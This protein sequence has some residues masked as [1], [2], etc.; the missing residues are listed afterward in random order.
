MSIKI[1][2]VG[3]SH[4]HIYN[5]VHALVSAGAELV[6][7]H[8]DEP[9][10]AAEFSARYPQAK[11]VTA[12]EQILEDESIHL[13]AS[14]PIPNQRAALGVQVMGH[15]KDYSCAKPA[16]T[17]L[18][19]LAEARAVQAQTKRI[20][21][22]HFGERYD[23]AATVKA[24]ELVHSGRIG[25][26]IH[27]IGIGPHKLLGHIPRP[28]WSFDKQYFG[29]VITDLASHQVDQFLYFTGSD[30]AQ[31]TLSQVGNLNHPQ[32]SDFEDF[33]DLTIRSQNATGY[34]RVDWFTPQGLGTWGDVRLFLMGTDGYI[35]VRKIID[36]GGREGGNHLFVVDQR[37]TEHIDCSSVPLPYGAQLIDDVLNR[38]ETAMNQANCFLACELALIAQRDAVKL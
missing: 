35:E 16:F 37:G 14:A 26:V 18:D 23:N 25:R 27:M 7:F 12:V 38:T 5:Q 28:E 3:L 19:Q 32:F 31:I 2:A 34:I 17:T 36:I 20:F 24:G 10:R 8:S 6:A 13:V 15:G 11:Q 1:A 21:T 22:V 4:P 30:S 33:G 29:G 9:E